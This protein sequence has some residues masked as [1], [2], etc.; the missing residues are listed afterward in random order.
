MSGYSRSIEGGDK[1]F[2]G[3]YVNSKLPN[4]QIY[5]CNI[6]TILNNN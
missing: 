6:F 5:A 4:D 3:V 2:G 1:L